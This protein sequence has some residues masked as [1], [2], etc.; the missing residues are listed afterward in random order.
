MRAAR[1]LSAIQSRHRVPRAR[2]ARHSRPRAANPAR[3][4]RAAWLRPVGSVP[5]ARRC[6]RDQAPGAGPSGRRMNPR[7]R[8]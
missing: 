3:A 8:S 5:P 1:C 7:S 2:P 6:C 4:R